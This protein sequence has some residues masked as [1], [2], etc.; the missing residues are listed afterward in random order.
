MSWGRLLPHVARSP[1]RRSLRLSDLTRLVLLGLTSLVLLGLPALAGASPDHESDF[2]ER[3]NADRA[4]VGVE[5]LILRAALSDVARD[6]SRSMAD[7]GALFHLL[8]DGLEVDGWRPSRENTGYGWSVRSTH[9]GLLASGIHRANLLDP[10]LTDVGIGVT[11]HDGRVWVT[12]LFSEPSSWRFA[13]VRPDGIH[14]PAI[15]RLAEAGGTGGCGDGRFCPDEVVTRA[16]FASL[17]ARAAALPASSS[18]PFVD[19][20]DIHRDAIGALV[21]A[22][23][24]GGCDPPVGE[25]FCPDDPVSRAQAATFLSRAL[26]LPPTDDHP[27]LDVSA[28]H[29]GN[30]GALAV[31][32]IA[33][34]CTEDRY[35]PDEPVTRA[36]AASLLVGSFDL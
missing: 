1:A 17:L 30:I 11:L 8:H 6:H 25:R 9:A 26:D 19:V 31:A 36:Q 16:Q 3:I 5:P 32:G 10:E 18:V 20:P 21:D 27:F 22:G 33:R 13:D 14:G 15:E 28:P 34:G 2:L 23:I 24:T 12:Q 4:E 29:A 35:C 7:A